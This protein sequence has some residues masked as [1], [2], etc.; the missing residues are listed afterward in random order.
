VVILCFHYFAAL[1]TNISGEEEEE[2]FEEFEEQAQ[3]H[4]AHQGKPSKFVA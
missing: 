4:I 1:D 2:E 3:G